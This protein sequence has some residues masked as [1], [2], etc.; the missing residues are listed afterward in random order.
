[1]NIALSLYMY[2]A[3]V[4]L[5]NIMLWITNEWTDMHV[6]K[7]ALFLMGGKCVVLG[8]LYTLPG[9]FILICTPM[10]WH[11]KGLRIILLIVSWKSRTHHRRP[12]PQLPV[13]NNIGDTCVVIQQDFFLDRLN[14][15]M[16]LKGVCTI[17]KMSVNASILYMSEKIYKKRSNS[18]HRVIKG[19]V[20]H[21]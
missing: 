6:C 9:L 20:Q 14:K 12:G 11:Q 10:K 17:G 16:V 3:V 8:S 21:W 1:M 18:F 19:K 15:F 13:E 2:V 4:M 7:Y 5:P